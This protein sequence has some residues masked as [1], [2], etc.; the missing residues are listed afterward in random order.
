MKSS[1]A[2]DTE[3]NDVTTPRFILSYLRPK[4]H[5]PHLLLAEAGIVRAVQELVAVV[6][7]QRLGVIANGFNEQVLAAAVQLLPL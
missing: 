7:L 1:R 5:P 6:A 3:V 4:Q 2:C